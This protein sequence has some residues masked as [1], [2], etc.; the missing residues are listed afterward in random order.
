MSIRPE[1]TLLYTLIELETR[2]KESL[3]QLENPALTEAEKAFWEI[4]L[5][6]VNNAQASFDADMV[7]D[8]LGMGLWFF[9]D[10]NYDHASEMFKRL[11][12]EFP[13]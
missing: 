5:K 7:S 4:H 11:K 8:P 3:R 13:Q 9:A 2:R 12:G 6:L 1:T 10:G